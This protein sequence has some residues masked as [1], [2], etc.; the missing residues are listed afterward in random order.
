M[1]WLVVLSGPLRESWAALEASLCDEDD[2]GYDDD[3]EEG[4]DD[5]DDV[6]RLEALSG[7]A[8]PVQRPSAVA[9]G[10]ALGLS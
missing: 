2:D 7:R 3:D 4:D 5:D 9:I 10:S 1:V 8:G 6:G